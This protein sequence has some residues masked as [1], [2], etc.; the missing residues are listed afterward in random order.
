MEP[1]P[2]NYSTCGRINQYSSG[3]VMYGKGQDKSVLQSKD[4]FIL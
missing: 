1:I 4:A 3:L 2:D